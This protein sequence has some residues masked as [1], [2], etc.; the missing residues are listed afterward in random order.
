MAVDRE[1]NK[2]VIGAY[3]KD[4]DTQELKKDLADR[5]RSYRLGWSIFDKSSDSTIRVFGDRNIYLEMTRGE[6]AVPGAF[7]SDKYTGSINAGVDEIKKDLKVDEKGRPRLYF[8]NTP[9][10]KPLIQA[11]M[12]IERDTYAN[13]DSKGKKD[14][15]KEGKWDLHACLRYIYQRTVRWL[16]PQEKMVEPIEER[17]I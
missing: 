7:K 12:S 2:Y 11:M 8:F 3:L 14:R 1:G 6:N 13:E 9:E 4:A 5:A 15:I 10:V 17:Y 16:P